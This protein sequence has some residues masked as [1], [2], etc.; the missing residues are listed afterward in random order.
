MTSPLPFV[1]SQSVALETGHIWCGIFSIP[2][3][4][5]RSF[6]KPD[7]RKLQSEMVISPISFYFLNPKENG[8]K[9]SDIK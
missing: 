7:E 9:N 1:F 2:H 3:T 6:P 8:D 4:F 5:L